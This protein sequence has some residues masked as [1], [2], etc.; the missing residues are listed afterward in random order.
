MIVIRFHPEI[1][2]LIWQL[3]QGTPSM[4][5][6]EKRKR[7]LTAG[8]EPSP[9]PSSPSGSVVSNPVPP[10]E[11][12]MKKISPVGSP[13]Y[14]PSPS[15]TR[16]PSATPPVGRMESDDVDDVDNDYVDDDDDSS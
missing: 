1:P 12:Q 10:S 13:S 4:E 6:R 15:S 9:T 3:S 7:Q 14:S 8:K 2:N 5:T 16:P 11:K